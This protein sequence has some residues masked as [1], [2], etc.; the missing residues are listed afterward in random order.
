MATESSRSRGAFLLTIGFA[1]LLAGCATIQGRLPVPVTVSAIPEIPGIPEARFWGDE[2]PPYTMRRLEE[3]DDAD[4]RFLFRGVV[5][6]PHDYLAISGGGPTGAF[7]AGLL[8]GWT[9]SGTRTEF[10]MVTGVS[11]GALTAPFAFLGPK[12]DA[13]LEDVYTTIS[14]KDVIRKRNIIAAAMSD[15]LAGT[16]PLK[17]LIAKYITGEILQGIAEAHKVGRRLFIGTTNLDAGRAVI[18]NIGKIATSGQIDALDVVRKIMLASASI[19]GAFPPVYF[20][21]EAEDGKVYDEMHVDGGTASQVFIYPAALNWRKI[22]EKLKVPGL[23]QVYV[24]RNAKLGAAAKPVG[25]TLVPIAT[26]SIASLIRTQGFGDLYQIHALT[27]RDGTDFNLA[28]VPSDFEAESKE[29]FDPQYMRALFDR[30][31]EM[32]KAGYPW[33]KAPPGFSTE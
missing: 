31:Y 2:V 13:T 10:T 3:F 14:T 15:A 26:R 22:L 16:E 8:K 28:Y 24:I 33:K 17:A 20:E 11:T 7:G 25:P 18:W 5:E 12:Y 1:V 9:A 30:G 23:P 32:A 27:K 21:V 29:L 4:V 6:R 19:P